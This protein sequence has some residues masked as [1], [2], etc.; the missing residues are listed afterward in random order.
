MRRSQQHASRKRSIRISRQLT[1]H[2]KLRQW[3]TATIVKP[4]ARYQCNTRQ[5]RKER[6][7]LITSGKRPNMIMRRVQPDW[8]RA[9]QEEA[10]VT[11]GLEAMQA[12]SLMLMR[13]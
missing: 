4:L 8:N 11:R 13:R 10:P 2:R 5:N 1:A 9:A 12:E 6:L 7:R 3:W